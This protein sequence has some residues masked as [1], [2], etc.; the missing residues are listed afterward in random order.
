MYIK[1]A[2]KTHWKLQKKKKKRKKESS[3]WLEYNTSIHTEDDG[4]KEGKKGGRE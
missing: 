3:A 4:V 2:I 1:Y